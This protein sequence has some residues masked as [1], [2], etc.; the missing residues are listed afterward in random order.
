MS[1]LSV[2][3]IKVFLCESQP[4]V[5]EGLRLA[6]EA[7]SDLML[8]GAADHAQALPAI[9]S[10]QPDVV[11]ISLPEEPG[12]AFGWLEQL[13]EA[14]PAAKCVLWVNDGQQVD[15][16][17][18]RRL[19]VRAVL[20]R[21]LPAAMLVDCLTTVGRG[22]AW[23]DGADGRCDGSRSAPRLT[24]RERQIV[25]LLSRG[26]KNKQIAEALAIAPGTVKV[27]L[28]HIFE[29]TGARN[30][31]ELAV[32]ARRLIPAEDDRPTGSGLGLH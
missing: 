19:G 5:V 20:P 7:S 10:L 24:P 15:A 6:L 31:Y 17:R 29:K 1:G 12:D 2:R 18:A 4:I 27:H 9:A 3:L 25:R 11:L 21:R 28:M 26:L 22:G 8:V 23:K 32:R 13:R 16:A 14:C 30:R